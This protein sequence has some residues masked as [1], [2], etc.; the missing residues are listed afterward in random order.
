ML[1]APSAGGKTEAVL[2]TLRTQPPGQVL[3]VVP[4]RL[5]QRFLRARL[6]GRRQTH[7]YQ[8]T[9]LVRLV[10]R[11]AGVRTTDLS[12]PMRLM[13]LRSVMQN[14]AADGQLPHFSPV[15]HKPGFVARMGSLIAEAQE[16]MVVPHRWKTAGVTPYDHELGSISERYQA[17]LEQT[18]L[19]DY[20]RR[21][22]LAREALQTAPGLLPGLDLL[23]V[24]GF[25]QF[26]PLQ[27]EL[28]AALTRCSRRS[29]ITLTGS[30]GSHGS[31]GERPAHRRF[32]RTYAHLVE[33]LRP[34]VQPVEATGPPPSAVF[35]HIEAHLFDLEVPPPIQAGG[36]LRYIEAADREREV[37]EVLRYVRQRLRAGVRLEQVAILFRSGH[38]Y[39]PLLR[40]VAAEYGVPLALCDGRPLGEAPQIVT[41]LMLLRLP[42]ENYPR[43]LLVEV[44]RGLVDGRL[45]GMF[46]G[47]CQFAAAHSPAVVGTTAMGFE[48]A[49]SLLD[50]A[51]REAG[52]L[53]GLFRLRSLLGALARATPTP[54]PADG[55]EE[56]FVPPVNPTDA[57]EVLHLLE[58]FA[59]WLK[60]PGKATTEEYAAWVRA[61]YAEASEDG[62]EE[63]G[64]QAEADG[65]DLISTHVL[66]LLNHLATA[67]TA[68]HDPAITYDRFL[69]DVSAALA[70]ARFGHTD[71][72]RGLV[73]VLP[74]GEA[75]GLHVDHLVL[76]GLSEGE[77][78]PVVS[79]PPIYSRRERAMLAQRGVVLPPPDPADERSLFYET[80]GLAR[81]SL[82][83][84]RTYLDEQGNLLP[85][86]PYLTALL[87]LALPESVP[88]VR[89]RAG[90]VPVLE[91]AASPQEA[92]VAVMAGKGDWED[93]TTAAEQQ[94]GP[95]LRSLREHVTRAC[96]VERTREGAGD[97][98]PG[99][100]GGMLEDP[101]LV[102]EVARRFGPDYHWSVTR[103]NDYLTCPFR[104]AAAHVLGL[105]QRAEPEEGL[106]SA[107]RGRIYHDILALAGQ[108]WIQ[109]HT[110]FATDHEQAILD[111]LHLAIDQVLAHAPAHYGFDPGAFWGW[112]QADV[113]RRLVQAIRRAVREGGEWAAFRP[114]EVERGFG[115]QAGSAPLCLKTPAGPV[116][117][118]GRVDR[119]DVRESGTLALLDYKSSSKVRSLRDTLEGRD[120]QLS[121]YLL[122]VEQVVRPGEHV[123]RAAFFHLGSGKYSPPLTDRERSRALEVLMERLTEVVTSVREGVFPV[124]P[125]R[126][127]PRSCP[128]AT[129]CRV[130]RGS[131]GA[132]GEDGAS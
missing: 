36:M 108:A 113:R 20:A 78:P 129:I 90:S 126:A 82:T 63:G 61:R 106:E 8:L 132:G 97:P 34:V 16:A 4:S 38:A 68:I 9:G 66:P 55:D 21:L 35:S 120:V 14:L 52:V 109:A 45:S 47:F 28:I 58:A 22:A 40:E 95:P 88:I 59:A 104:F 10:V 92:L 51:A 39:E 125:S 87:R 54:P 46:R 118:V 71:P 33:K 19:A 91:D 127:C 65:P 30:H 85:P 131:R 60:P 64:K 50:R 98:S 110:L 117:V 67:A 2:R 123:E 116:L 121:L 119:V 24:D 102:A 43:R 11:L 73:A 80:V 31:H 32:A 77:V 7:V 86:S 72:G 44:W 70:L 99:P 48:R 83:L 114:V 25:D 26:T 56:T 17:T 93:R 6:Q 107:G 29:I 100:F 89:V 62:E 23:V 18:G 5:Q 37:R 27:L 124:R 111:A 79:D 94:W 57:Q 15:A 53:A 130:Q 3:L 112:E 69:S 105:E 76:L 12:D 81:R 128:F 115:I 75:R 122:A 49:A 84:T 74:M 13:V 1:V 103:F 101:V 41:L 96:H 42:L